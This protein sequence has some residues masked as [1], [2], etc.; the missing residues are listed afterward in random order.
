ML[1][2]MVVGSQFTYLLFHNYLSGPTHLLIPESRTVR[3]TSC[4]LIFGVYV[5]VWYMQAC[6][7]LCEGAPTHACICREAKGQH[8]MLFST[9]FLTYSLARLVGKLAL[10][11]TFS[12]L[13]LPIKVSAATPSSLYVCWEWGGI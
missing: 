1:E 3:K 6:I 10:G 5:H 7:N 11:L 12:T 13:L 9:A 8:Y 2:L 4:H